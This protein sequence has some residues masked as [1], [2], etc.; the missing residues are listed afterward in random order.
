MTIK[1]L[2]FF[3]LTISTLC[4]EESLDIN[5]NCEHGALKDSVCDC[6][7]GYAKL[8]ET[9]PCNYE[10]HKQLTSFLIELFTNLGIGHII[11][12]KYVFG[13]SKMALGI[14][15]WMFNILGICGVIRIKTSQG[16]WGTFMAVFLFVTSLAFF[17]WWIVDAVIF[18]LNKYKD[19]NSI[20]LEP[21]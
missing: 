13:F 7:K 2:L 12:G 1:C 14:I 8:N 21:W 9:G 10:K 18:G 16:K 5:I 6:D 11:L 17:I 3:I 20:E 19:A 4:K 15:P